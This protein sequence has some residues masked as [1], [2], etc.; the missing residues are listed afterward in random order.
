MKMNP[1]LYRHPKPL[2]IALSANRGDSVF[3]NA[4]LKMHSPLV[5]TADSSENEAW[6]KPVDPEKL[7]MF[8]SIEGLKA[9]R[10]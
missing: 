3:P 10:R 8:R 4:R 5:S 9:E 2:T 6:I 7:L 1:A